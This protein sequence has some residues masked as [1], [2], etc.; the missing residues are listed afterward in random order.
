METNEPEHTELPPALIVIF[1][2][3]GD[4]STRKLLPSLYQLFKGDFLN[5]KTTIVG[6]SRQKISADKILKKARDSICEID[7]KC[8]RKILKKMTK[9]MHVYTM[10]LTSPEHYA[11]LREHLDKQEE[12]AGVC[13]NRLFYLSIPPQ[14]YR[15]V[16]RQLG[17]QKL[18]IGCQKHDGAARLLIEKPFGYDLASAQDLIEEMNVHFQENQIFRIDHY[19]AKETAQ[20]ILAFRFENPMFEA[21]WNHEHIAGIDVFAIEK[22]DIEG[23]ANFYD[24]IGAM[25]DLIQSHLLQIL[26]ITTMEQ[27]AKIDSRDIHT[28]K[29]KLLKSIQPIPAD[30]I[31][32][33]TI[34]AQ[35]D[36][37]K[38][39]VGNPRSTTETFA[40]LRLFI[41][42][43]RWKNVPITIWTG[44]ALHKKQTGV[45]MHFRQKSID[46][47]SNKLTFAIQPHEGISLDLFV[48]QP[49]FHHKLHETSMSF[50]YE[51]TFRQEDHPTAYE[52][53]LVDAIRGDRTLFTSSDEILRAWA[54][55]QPII[56]A[57]QGNDDGLQSYPQHSNGP[58][59]SKLT[60]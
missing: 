51:R 29:L 27:P 43:P 55:L 13:M 14:V 30:K 6:I 49:G 33:R 38:K 40:A 21:V 1:G 45:V 53:V 34:R 5:E 35:Y 54:I 44:K 10:D 28:S 32:T 8:D 58:D 19:L 2:I 12:K 17:E 20:N 56:D 11:G 36:G 41:D 48:K 26:A 47:R 60:S 4:L 25:R 15:P 39:Q 52:R 46:N 31:D 50:S 16:V 7:G 59:T 57:W 42:N 18:N 24:S 23:R 3:S 22:I 37:Y 9:K